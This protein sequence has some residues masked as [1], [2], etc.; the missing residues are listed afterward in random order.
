MSDTN[1]EN[2]YAVI[3]YDNFHY[4]DESESYVQGLYASYGL[5]LETAQRLVREDLESRYRPGM[6]ALELLD[7]Y[8]G[9]GVDPIVSPSDEKESFSAW[10][11]AG[12]HCGTLCGE[13]PQPDSHG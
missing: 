11:Y 13:A 3:V 12:F 4:M 1:S 5:A 10:A 9:F 2:P 8:K 7:L 6:K